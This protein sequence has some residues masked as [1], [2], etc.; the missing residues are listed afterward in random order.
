MKSLLAFSIALVPTLA[1]GVDYFKEDFPDFKPSVMS[2]Q[3]KD[4][5]VVKLPL[6]LFGPAKSRTA[7]ESFINEDARSTLLPRDAA[8]W[9]MQTPDSLLVTQRILNKQE[10]TTST[11]LIPSNVMLRYLLFAS[12]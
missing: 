3:L 6:D 5:Y 10:N 4:P 7:P 12:E 9:G 2:P 8:T 11:A 1:Y